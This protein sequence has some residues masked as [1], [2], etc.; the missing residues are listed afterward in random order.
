M[1]RFILLLSAV[2][3]LGCPSPAKRPIPDA[4]M[5]GWSPAGL[6]E[7]REFSD[8]IGSAAVMIVTS[9][10][11]VDAWGDLSHRYR[12]HSIR[13]S[14]LSALCGIAI[15]EGSL[16]LEATLESL[17]IDD[18]N[19][20]LRSSERQATVMQL[21]QSRSGVYHPAASEER[22]ARES[23]PPR[24]SHQPGTFWYYNNWDFNALGTIFEQASGRGIDE[25]FQD[26]IAGPIGMQDFRP[27]DFRYQLEP[28]HSIHPSYKFRISARDL[29]RFGQLF[30]DEGRWGREQIVPADWVR[31]STEV[32]SPTGS[33]GSKSGFGL[34]W[35]VAA[36]SAADLGIPPGAFTAS[37]SRGQRLTVLPDI[38]T[39]VVHLMDT[40]DRDGPR[41]G[42][43]TYNEFL[44]RLMRARR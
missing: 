40:D 4:K 8:S 17:D 15:E 38:D 3:I 24:G 42:T 44:A 13:K 33:K 6:A 22:S 43:S 14:F 11:T 29:A 18:R 19:P 41:I 39:V 20:A 9:G 36:E 32:H 37:G 21:L 26:W 1:R 35:W 27:E 10:K 30:L 5:S 25:A 28:E 2:L 31:L 12:A 7:L 34:M 16:E 23:R